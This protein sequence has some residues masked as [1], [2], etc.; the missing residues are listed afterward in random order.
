MLRKAYQEALDEQ[1]GVVAAPLL[2][3]EAAIKA[4]GRGDY[5]E[6]DEGLAKAAFAAGTLYALYVSLRL[7][8]EG[9]L[10]ASG[11][12]VRNDGKQMAHATAKANWMKGKK[13]AEKGSDVLHQ[14]FGGL[15]LS[16]L[17]AVREA[18][19]VSVAAVAPGDFPLEAQR[20][21]EMPPLVEA[22][23]RMDFP[24]RPVGYLAISV[25]AAAVLAGI[26]V[27]ATAPA[28]SFGRMWVRS[29]RLRISKGLA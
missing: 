4:V 22:T 26:I 15:A 1:V 9:L 28:M 3:V 10:V 18:P 23:P 11:R 14:L 13:P 29:G 20:P 24:L 8:A 17:P 21:P 16:Q 5:A 7:D 2:E 12:V 25:G 19:R 27:Y 6:S